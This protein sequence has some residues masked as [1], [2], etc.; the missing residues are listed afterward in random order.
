MVSGQRT[1]LLLNMT[2]FFLLIRMKV[3]VEIRADLWEPAGP[4]RRLTAKRD[5]PLGAALK[6]EHGP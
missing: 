6:E 4:W 2:Q 1:T 3:D 5:S